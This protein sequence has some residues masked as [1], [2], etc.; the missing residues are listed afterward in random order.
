VSRYL[1][2]AA[3]LLG[4]LAGPPPAAEPAR[5]PYRV[6]VVHSGFFQVIPAVTGLKNGLEAQGFDEGRDVVYEIRYTRGSTEAI[7]A[8]VAA[9][10]SGGYDLVFTWGEEVSR[11]MKSGAATTPMVFTN[12]GDPVAADLITSVPRP[13]GNVTG[14]YTLD[15][16]LVP[17]RFEILQ[18]IVPGLRRVWAVHHA[19]DRSMVSMARK[20][21]QVA[22]DLGLDVLV[23][24][25]RSGDEAVREL[26]AVRPGDALLA[27]SAL[28]GNIPGLMLDLGLL[29][30][31]PGVF[32][33]TFWARAG[34]L[35]S[36]GSD[37][38]SEGEQAARLVAK[39]LRGAHPRQLPVEGSSRIE[40]AVNLKTAKAMGLAV[41]SAVQARAEQVFD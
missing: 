31:V 40:L 2:V 15:V 9:V 11:A 12:V 41:P 13:G 10:A 20:A 30:R 36:Y 34:G 29:S 8:A 4:L 38:A 16:E 14:V 3:C 22:P 23:R 25:V 5:P 17:K 35:V 24:A 32:A 18:A 1:A 7:A 19:D 26:K 6:A 27:P 33:N 28:T 39:I 37:A 21:R